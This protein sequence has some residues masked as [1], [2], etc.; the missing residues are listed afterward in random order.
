ME[1]PGPPT[2]EPLL[3][4]SDSKLLDSFFQDMTSNHFP[5]SSFGEGLNFGSS[6]I[7]LPPNF[8]GVGTS[9][10]DGAASISPTGHAFQGHDPM[11]GFVGGGG[12]SSGGGAASAPPSNSHMMPPPPSQYSTHHLQDRH[13]Q[14][15]PQTHGGHSDDVLH[16]AATLLQNNGN[17]GSHN[18][19]YGHGGRRSITGLEQSD[20]RGHPHKMT[21][22]PVGHLRHQRLEDFQEEGRREAA[23]DVQPTDYV[24]L[25][26][27]PQRKPSRMS[28]PTDFQWGSDA[29]FSPTQGYIPETNKQTVESM[30][31]MQLKML[32]SLEVSGSAASTRPS[33]PTNGNGHHH[34]HQHPHGLMT[35]SATLP[36]NNGNGRSSLSGMPD[37]DAPPRKRRKSRI[38]LEGSASVDD[39]DDDGGSSSNNSA[40]TQRR[41][42]SSNKLPSDDNA[43]PPGRQRRGT[44]DAMAAAAAAAAAGGNRPA[45]ETL[46]EEQK[47]SNHIK[48][49]Q[50]R[51]TLIKT[52]FHDLC[53]L[54]PSLQGGGFSKSS[55]LT[56]AGEWLQE[57]LRGNEL[58]ARQAAEMGV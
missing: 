10:P 15:H 44:M 17:G 31:R 28:L 26:T 47:R 56:V 9:Y 14:H 55:M 19:G 42:K 11:G 21:V 4:A 48:S 45:R 50:K 54:V 51:R 18:N 49:E 24:N 7:D 40:R 39:S 1:P 37:V 38:K 33:S 13:H 46:S 25:L 8:M 43:W 41:R 58:L 23:A 57:L 30:Q 32:D 29:N 53:D 5:I 36:S 35:P 16:A 3:D 52:G 12:G 6:L 2:G 20:P 34:H 27:H 22:P